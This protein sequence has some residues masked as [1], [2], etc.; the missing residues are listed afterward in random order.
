MELKN[1]VEK[2]LARCMKGK[3]ADVAIGPCQRGKSE[4]LYPEVEHGEAQNKEAK[5]SIVVAAREHETHKKKRGEKG[6][7]VGGEILCSSFL[8]G[9]HV[10]NTILDQEEG[11]EKNRSLKRRKKKADH[12]EQLELRHS[13]KRLEHRG[14]GKG[15]GNGKQFKE[16]ACSLWKKRK[17]ARSNPEKLRLLRYIKKTRGQVV[18]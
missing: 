13:S 15:G 16:G 2:N 3:R 9:S 11:G 8:R 7:R 6:G 18:P 14:D 1:A 4:M 17:K 10:E 5:K 12:F